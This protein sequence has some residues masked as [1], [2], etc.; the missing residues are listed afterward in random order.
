VDNFACVYCIPLSLTWNYEIFLMRYQFLF[1][2]AIIDPLWF[3]EL[4]AGRVD[5]SLESRKKKYI[6]HVIAIPVVHFFSSVS[7]VWV[8]GAKTTGPIT[9][10]FGFS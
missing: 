4:Q 2:V 6:I 8:P 9:K 5:K 1:V 10:K 7:Y 3:Y